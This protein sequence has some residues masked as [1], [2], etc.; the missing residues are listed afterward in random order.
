MWDFDIL[1]IL[2]INCDGNF[3]KCGDFIVNFILKVPILTSFISFKQKYNN[4]Y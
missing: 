2:K 3:M 1:K 4:H